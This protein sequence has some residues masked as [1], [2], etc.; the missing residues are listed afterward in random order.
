MPRCSPPITASRR[1]SSATSMR[2]GLLRRLRRAPER[3]HGG[4]PG[5]PLG[6]LHHLN[7]RCGVAGY[8]GTRERLRRRAVRRLP[9][10]RR[11]LRDRVRH[12]RGGG[13][14]VCPGGEG[15]EALPGSSRRR[16]GAR[17]GDYGAAH[18]AYPDGGSP[19]GAAAGSRGPE[20]ERPLVELPAAQAR[21]GPPA[22]ENGTSR[23][24]T[25]TG[26]ARS[27]PSHCR[28]SS[29]KTVRSTSP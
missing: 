22:A 3:G 15:R 2:N 6:T 27:G 24:P 13:D 1:C 8:R 20:L 23:R 21:P 16:R 7:G 11:G 26:S 29:P 28:G 17:F 25:T 9:A 5:D 12:G 10:A 14:R 4:L 18:P 19:G